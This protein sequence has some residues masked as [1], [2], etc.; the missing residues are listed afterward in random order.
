MY[1]FLLSGKKVAERIKTV[2][3]KKVYE[4]R[5]NRFFCRFVVDVET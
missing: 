1:F 3:R 4:S 5:G 2:F